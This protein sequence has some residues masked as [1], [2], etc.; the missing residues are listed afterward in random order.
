[1]TSQVRAVAADDAVLSV[2]WR[3]QTQA[4]E[5]Y[6]LVNTCLIFHVALSTESYKIFLLMHIKFFYTYKISSKYR[7]YDIEMWIGKKARDKRGQILSFYI[8]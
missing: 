4:K 7:N 5:P 6:C 1:M 3:A 2:V 8:L